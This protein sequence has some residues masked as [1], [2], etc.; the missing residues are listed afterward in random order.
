V[1]QADAVT[2]TH[3]KRRII[4]LFIGFTLCGK[5]ISHNIVLYIHFL[6]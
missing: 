1:A 3:I 5:V 2:H 6:R 4:L